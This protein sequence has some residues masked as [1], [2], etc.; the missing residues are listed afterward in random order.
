MSTPNQPSQQKNLCKQWQFWFVILYISFI[1]LYTFGFISSEG[2]NQLLSSNEL[3]DFL[4]GSFAPLA[5]LFLYLGYKQQGKELKQNTEALLLQAQALQ[6]SVDEQKALVQTAKDELD[7]LAAQHQ[8][9]Q[10][11]LHRQLK[12]QQLQDELNSM[13]VIQ[14]KFQGSSNNNMSTYSIIN[15]GSPIINVCLIADQGVSE[16]TSHIAV[17]KTATIQQDLTISLNVR[18]EDFSFK[19]KFTTV[20]GIEYEQTFKNQK[21]HHDQKTSVILAQGT[22]VKVD[23]VDC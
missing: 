9:N 5:F 19:I 15:I 11:N 12:N 13:P 17:L 23:V 18:R 7:F 3:G 6:N 22:P 20:K 21:L 14:F 4:A 2:E 16:I 1:A 8:E 10:K